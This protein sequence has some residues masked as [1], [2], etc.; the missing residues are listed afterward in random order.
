MRNLSEALRRIA[1]W[2]EAEL[3]YLNVLQFPMVAYHSPY[4]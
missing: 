4:L 2:I 3:K 1:L